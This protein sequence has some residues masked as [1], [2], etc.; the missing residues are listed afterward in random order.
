[1]VWIDLVLA[2]D[3]ETGLCEINLALDSLECDSNGLRQSSLV[4]WMAQAAGFSQAAFHATGAKTTYLASVNHLDYASAEIWGAFQT[5][6]KT[7]KT[8]KILVKTQLVRAL[9]PITLFKGEV[10]CGD[11]ILGAGTFKTYSD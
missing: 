3:A 7:Q 2:A 4:E 6:L 9:G 11:K 10:I 8:V 5:E 1:M